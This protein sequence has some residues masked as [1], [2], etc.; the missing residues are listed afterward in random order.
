VTLGPFELITFGIGGPFDV[1][2]AFTEQFELTKWIGTGALQP[3]QFL[4]GDSGE[5]AGADNPNIS[6]EIMGTKFSGMGTET[7]TYIFKP[8]P[9]PASLHM[10]GIAVLVMAG[11][12]LRASNAR[13]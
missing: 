5:G 2:Q 9:E 10:M 1:E 8:V 6:I 4:F 12:G 3:F 13:R 7:I 11:A